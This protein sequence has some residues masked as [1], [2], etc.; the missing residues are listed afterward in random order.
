ML[1]LVHLAVL[2]WL[3]LELPVANLPY[4]RLVWAAAL[5]L[6]VGGFLGPIVQAV[7]RARNKR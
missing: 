4:S 1:K 3:L 7:L 2:V 5:V 6:L